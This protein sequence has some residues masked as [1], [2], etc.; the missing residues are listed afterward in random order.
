MLMD[1]D[2]MSVLPSTSYRS[3]Y[4]SITGREYSK[5]PRGRLKP[6]I[7]VEISLIF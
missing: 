6:G 7:P 1:S 4:R 2:E 3:W 5:T